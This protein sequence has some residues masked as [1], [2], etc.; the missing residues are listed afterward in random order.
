MKQLNE[1]IF[2]LI[3]ATILLI[4][5]ALP[6]L[7]IAL[8]IL[9]FLARPIIFKQQRTGLNGQLF[10]I[11]KFRTLTNAKG[12]NGA[13]LDDE[14]RMHWF[15]QLLRRLSLDELPQLFNVMKGDL[16]FVGPRP[17]LPEY[18]PLYT[19]E[20]M[21]RHDVKPGITGWAQINGRNAIDWETKFQYD[22]WYVDN[23][24]F[25]LDLKILW[26]T[27]LKFL[28]VEAVNEPGHVTAKKFTGK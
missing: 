6:M 13:L 22:V 17:L 3:L 2:D 24:S 21:R 12:A 16:R 9:I 26:L 11:Y 27:L 23:Q 25:A 20:Q 14:Y 8:F 4:I 19:K 15:G 7:I 5:F 1:R 10:T 28:K 18:L